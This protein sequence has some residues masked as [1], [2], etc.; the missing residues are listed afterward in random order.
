MID[1][2]KDRTEKVCIHTLRSHCA[3]AYMLSLSLRNAANP[4]NDGES[5]VEH[6]GRSLLR[7]PNS[8]ITRL[9]VI[10][11]KAV[12]LGKKKKKNDEQQQGRKQGI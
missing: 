5:G 9:S 3:F 12:D 6:R 10:G 11:Q 8:R 2:C 4:R 7:N 1:D